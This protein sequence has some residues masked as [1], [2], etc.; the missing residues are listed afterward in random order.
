MDREHF[1]VGVGSRRFWRLVTFLLVV[2]VVWVA[3]VAWQTRPRPLVTDLAYQSQ[4]LNPRAAATG[5]EN[6]ANAKKKGRPSKQLLWAQLSPQQ[7]NLLRPLEHQWDDLSALERKHLLVAVKRYTSMSKQQQERYASR[8]LQW[9]KMTIGQRNQVRK[10][11]VEYS[12]KKKEIRLD[13]ERK[14]E[15]QQ[16]AIAQMIQEKTEASTPKPQFGD[17]ASIERNQTAIQT[18]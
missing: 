9:S 2:T 6:T 10:R 3:L 18:H 11:Y 7:H 13:I 16:S 15:A 17:A 4:T 12:K 8:L 5:P 1:R 14:W